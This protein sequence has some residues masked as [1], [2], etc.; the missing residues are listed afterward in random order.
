MKNNKSK[1]CENCGVELNRHQYKYC[2]NR[3]QSENQYREQIDEWKRG[4]KDGLKGE[5]G[6]S[7]Y[8]R[9]YMFEKSSNKC[10]KCGWGVVNPY[11]GNTPLEVHHKDG[12]YKN[13]TEENLELLCPNC[14]SL[15]ATY[16]ALN[17]NGRKQR[18]KYR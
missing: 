13:N 15:T 18:T 3:C 5:Y 10:M 16:K 2:S 4:E 8:I 12:D 11:T 6:L 7:A 1:C 14:H 9:R 17:N